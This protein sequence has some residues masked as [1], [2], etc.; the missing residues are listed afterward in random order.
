MRMPPGRS[1]VLSDWGI[2]GGGVDVVD[3]VGV[4]VRETG[5]NRGIGGAWFGSGSETR[6]KPLETNPPV[7]LWSTA[8]GRNRHIARTFQPPL[9]LAANR[10]VAD[11]TADQAGL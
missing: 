1:I 3:A 11:T 7:P 8:S 2:E 4:A 5:R 9:S 10:Q 6:L